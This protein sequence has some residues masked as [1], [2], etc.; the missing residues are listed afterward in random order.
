MSSQPLATLLDCIHQGGHHGAG[1]KPKETSVVHKHGRNPAGSTKHGATAR[2]GT[3]PSRR[4][5]GASANDPCRPRR[6][7]R[8]ARGCDWPFAPARGVAGQGKQLTLPSSSSIM[9]VLITEVMDA[10]IR[11]SVPA[12][13]PPG[14]LG[15]NSNDTRLIV[16]PA[17]TAL[18]AAMPSLPTARFQR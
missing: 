8:V 7:A 18:D 5:Q 10:A 14:A 4:D 1:A 12:V 11:V 15:G 9:I 16:T 13:A 3:V 2:R 17:T 6:T